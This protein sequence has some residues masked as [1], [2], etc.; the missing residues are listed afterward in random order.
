[1]QQKVHEIENIRKIRNLS[2]GE[3]TNWD[4]HLPLCSRRTTVETFQ[5]RCSAFGLKLS[6]KKI[7]NGLA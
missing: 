5:N 2:A 6:L 7:K 4:N 1:M 3:T